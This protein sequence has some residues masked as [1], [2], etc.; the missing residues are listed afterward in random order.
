VTAPDRT[1]TSV[2]VRRSSIV[3]VERNREAEAHFPLTRQELHF[4]FHA[5]LRSFFLD[6][7]S[8]CAATAEAPT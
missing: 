1:T 5:T 4:P 8:S 2:P 6:G 3:K 7:F